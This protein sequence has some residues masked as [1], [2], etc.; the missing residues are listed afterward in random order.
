MTADGWLQFSVDRHPWLRPSLFPEKCVVQYPIWK[1]VNKKQVSGCEMARISHCCLY[2]WTARPDRWW[3]SDD[4]WFHIKRF[5]VFKVFSWAAFHNFKLKSLLPDN[6]LS[7]ALSEMRDR[8]VF[9]RAE[10]CHIK[11]LTVR[12]RGLLK[13]KCPGLFRY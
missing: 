12:N 7:V 9:R 3:R 11:K 1:N 10:V 4:F 8:C 2:V 13:Y 5:D 6:S